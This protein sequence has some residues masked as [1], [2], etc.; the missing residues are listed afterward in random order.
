MQLLFRRKALSSEL[1]SLELH[2]I[3]IIYFILVFLPFLLCSAYL[4]ISQPISFRADL[5]PSSSWRRVLS[6]FKK[7]FCLKLCAY[8]AKF[9]ILVWTYHSVLTIALSLYCANEA[10]H[11]L[12]IAV[13]LNYYTKTSLRATEVSDQTWK[14]YTLHI[15]NTIACQ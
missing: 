15:C 7:T 6:H 14:I 2:H 11:K 12:K 3:M 9:S 1:M 8:V 13:D 4:D 10:S 5:T